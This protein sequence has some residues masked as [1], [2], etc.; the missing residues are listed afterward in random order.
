[1]RTGIDIQY[2]D[3]D[4]LSGIN[5]AN[6]VANPAVTFN[7]IS[8]GPGAGTD[9]IYSPTISTKGAST[10]VMDPS[11][12]TETEAVEGASKQGKKNEEPLTA[13]ELAAINDVMAS[14]AGSGALPGLI[15][16]ELISSE[17]GKTTMQVQCGMDL[18]GNGII[19]KVTENSTITLT[20]V[21]D[22]E[23]VLLLLQDLTAGNFQDFNNFNEDALETLSALGIEFTNQMDEA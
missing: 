12:N 7:D 18:T 19:D 6:Q 23:E 9:Q 1:M 5:N 10:S 17:G 4:S 22:A 15:S 16:S 8:V 14:L 11:Y 21:E 20:Q 2:L 3:I 13:E